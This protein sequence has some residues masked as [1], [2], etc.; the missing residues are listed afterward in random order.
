M[1][2]GCLQLP[3]PSGTGKNRGKKINKTFACV[4]PSEAGFYVAKTRRLPVLWAKDSYQHEFDSNLS[5]SVCLISIAACGTSVFFGVCF[6]TLFG[7]ALV[8]RHSISARRAL[9]GCFFSEAME[10]EPFQAGCPVERLLPRI[11]GAF[12]LEWALKHV[13]TPK[14]LLICKKH[15]FSSHSLCLLLSKFKDHLV[16]Q[17]RGIRMF[18]HVHLTNLWRLVFL[19]EYFIQHPK[20]FAS[21]PFSWT[22]GSI[23]RALGS[24]SRHGNPGRRPSAAPGRLR[25]KRRAG[26]GRPTMET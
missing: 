10:G 22:V 16:K 21:K 8:P 6:Y 17:K 1:C 9:H 24:S 14:V 15:V 13:E 23:Q 3:W 25:R 5:V 26:L 11:G 18:H 2:L 4:H 20:L 12:P 7:F 19:K